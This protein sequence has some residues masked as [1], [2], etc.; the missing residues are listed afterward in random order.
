MLRTQYSHHAETEHW[1]AGER[2]PEYERKWRSWSETL[3]G[4]QPTGLGALQQLLVS[5][6]DPPA[7]SLDHPVCLHLH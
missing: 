1:K 5:V 2:A 3:A 4:I 7:R 6:F